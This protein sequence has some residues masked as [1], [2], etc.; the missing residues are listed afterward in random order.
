VNKKVKKV[1]TTSC[2]HMVRLGKR[3]HTSV[4]GIISGGRKTFGKQHR[5]SLSS[6]LEPEGRKKEPLLNTT[7]KGKVAE[8]GGGLTFAIKG[9]GAR[10][11]PSIT[12]KRE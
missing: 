4:S 10:K 3:W 11:T 12:G 8:E 6:A 7:K 1:R 5:A 9:N 2:Y